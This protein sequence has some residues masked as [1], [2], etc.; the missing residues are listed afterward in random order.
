MNCSKFS[1]WLLVI[2]GR[3][4]CAVSALIMLSLGM[5][6]IARAA[7]VV[8]INLNVNTYAGTDLIGVSPQNSG[9][10]YAHASG[11]WSGPVYSSSW[12]G[13]VWH[14]VSGAASID[15]SS[16]VWGASIETQLQASLA[17]DRAGCCQ[18]GGC[19]A[20]VSMGGTFQIGTTA[21]IPADTLLTLVV[22]VER[23][24]D[25]IDPGLM[26]FRL[27]L[28]DVTEGGKFE[29]YAGEA[30][31]VL[32]YCGVLSIHDL[33]EGS[34]ASSLS[35]SLAYRL[36]VVLE[37]LRGD[38]NKDGTVDGADLNTVLSYYNQTVG[39]DWS[40]GDFNGDGT[41]DGSDLNMVLSNYNQSV[42]L[43]ANVPEP[44]AL[45]M[46]I[47]GAVGVL[48][49]KGIRNKQDSE[50]GCGRAAK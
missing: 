20:T 1:V 32:S 40:Y 18:A 30:L 17:T 12:D 29:V 22:D 42:G 48:A 41:V 43:S 16:G 8:P 49:W 6:S 31:S 19:S 28:L 27:G 33:A 4:C 39:M 50:R 15:C 46:L 11:S 36:R 34:Y 21:E 47:V 3:L 24:G 5:C 44:G 35:G 13:P 45:V 14:N 7:S 37:P 26:G 25:A 38:A 23:S 9:A 10:E 2:V